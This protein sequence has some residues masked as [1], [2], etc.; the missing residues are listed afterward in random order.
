MNKRDL[1]INI[2]LD[3]KG[4]EI[5]I[6]NEGVLKNHGDYDDAEAFA[7]IENATY[8]LWKDSFSFDLGAKLFDTDSPNISQSRDL[9][10][11]N[12]GDTCTIILQQPYDDFFSYTLFSGHHYDFLYYKYGDEIHLRL[13]QTDYS[14]ENEKMSCTLTLL[15][16]VI[17]SQNILD[18]WEAVKQQEYLPRLEIERCFMHNGKLRQ[19]YAKGEDIELPKH[20]YD[21]VEMINCEEVTTRTLQKCCKLNYTLKNI[22]NDSIRINFNKFQI[23][24]YYSRD[25]FALSFEYHGNDSRHYFC[26]TDVLSAIGCKSNSIP[27]FKY[28]Y[29]GEMM[30]NYLTE[31]LELV[32]K[33]YNKLSNVRRISRLMRNYYL[34]LNKSLIK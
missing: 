32:E 2:P 20:E 4:N 29:N 12:L 23:N 3:D 5:I 21:K 18:K 33:Y 9:Y 6:T 19:Q 13:F 26:L 22:G 14:V 30:S 34:T 17:L 31:Y 11:K 1:Y 15:Y 7:K 16:K 8:F 25:G 24:L 10:V 27:E 28:I